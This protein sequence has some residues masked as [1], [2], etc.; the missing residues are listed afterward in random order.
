MP[1]MPSVFTCHSLD[2][3]IPILNKGLELLWFKKEINLQLPSE[4]GNIGGGT[5]ITRKLSI[6]TPDPVY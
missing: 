6:P 1:S 3:I 4:E 5:N 2:Q